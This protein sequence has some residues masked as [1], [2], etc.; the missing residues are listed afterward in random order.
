MPVTDAGKLVGV[1]TDRDI[2]LLLGTESL[3]ER[4]R[5]LKVRDACALEAYVVELT[6]PL[7]KVLTHMAEGR[8]ASALIVKQGKLVGIFTATDACRRFAEFLRAEFER[9]SPEE[10]A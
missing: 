5:A 6:E 1:V 2:S 3:S 10:A 9:P 8:I 7:D 4:R